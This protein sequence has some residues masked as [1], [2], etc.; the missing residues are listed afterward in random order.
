VFALTSDHEPFGM[1][2]L[3][4]MAAG[5][6]LICSNCGGGAEVVLDIGMLFPLGDDDALAM[7][8]VNQYNERG[9][10]NV[11][12][13]MQKLQERFSDEAVR[14]RFWSLPFVSRLLNGQ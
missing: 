9:S 2:L 6:P 13:I 8:I 3:E 4:A 7:C 1:V 12:N 11:A 10:V 5:L 14:A